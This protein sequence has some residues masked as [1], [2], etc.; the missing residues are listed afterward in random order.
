MKVFLGLIG[1]LACGLAAASAQ[2]SGGEPRDSDVS[3][4]IPTLCVAAHLAESHAEG[5]NCP[6]PERFFKRWGITCNPLCYPTYDGFEME[7]RGACLQILNVLPQW[8]HCPGSPPQAL[9]YL[10]DEFRAKGYNGYIRAFGLVCQKF[11]SYGFYSC[12]GCDDVWTCLEDPLVVSLEDGHYALTDTNGGVQFDLNGDGET[13]QIPWTAGKDDA[14]LVL[15]RN[16]NGLIDDGRELFSH[17]S[18]QQPSRTPNGFR[19][20]RMFDEPLNGG[21][22][23]GVLNASDEIYGSL[24]LWL[25]AD[26]DGRTD[27]GELVSLA[28]VGLAEVE[29]DYTDALAHDDEH[30]NTFRYSAPTHFDDG[31]SVLAWAVFLNIEKCSGE[32]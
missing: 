22:D 8:L 7:T 3:P 14:F 29:L 31:R 12:N 19:A 9:F 17:V 6:K 16:G 32:D 1:L 13:E 20:L 21:N 11:A 18:P 26:R 25:D 10:G 27:T 5:P 23:D 4:R 15:D 30:G 28:S 24:M 2:E